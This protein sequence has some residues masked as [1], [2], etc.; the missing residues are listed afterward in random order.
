[1]SEPKEDLEFLQEMHF[2]TQKLL[3]GKYDITIVE[4]LDKMIE[5]WIDLIESADL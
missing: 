3:N 1:M 5:D 2:L 4:Q